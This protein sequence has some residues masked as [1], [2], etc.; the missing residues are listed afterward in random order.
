MAGSGTPGTLPGHRP[1]PASPLE[2]SPEAPVLLAWK[3]FYTAPISSSGLL[4]L[5]GVRPSGQ[6]ARLGDWPAAAGDNR[7]SSEWP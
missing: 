6:G 7:D 1:R 5:L 3:A 2:I 4:R